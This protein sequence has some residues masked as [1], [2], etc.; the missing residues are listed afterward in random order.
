[1]NLFGCILMLIFACF[2]KWDIEY[3]MY[4][5]LIVVAISID[6]VRRDIRKINKQR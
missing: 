2:C 1:M 6:D 4:A 5:T 3:L